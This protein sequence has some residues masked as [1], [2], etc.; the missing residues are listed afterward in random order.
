[1]CHALPAVRVSNRC[2]QAWPKRGASALRTDHLVSP[3][4]CQAARVSVQ[5]S[6]RAMAD[7]RSI[8]G[9][10]VRS[11]ATTQRGRRLGPACSRRSRSARAEREQPTSTTSCR[12]GKAEP[13]TSRTCRPSVTRAT[14]AKRI[15]MTVGSD[16]ELFEPRG[17]MARGQG[18]DRGSPDYPPRDRASPTEFTKN[19]TGLRARRGRAFTDRYSAL[20]GAVKI[21]GNPRGA[22]P[23]GVPARQGREIEMRCA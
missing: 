22:R 20:T 11:A 12:T 10:R 16:T 21:S 17:G 8:R 19:R 23:E 14:R 18:R 7:A 2:A 1:M 9:R 4:P 13:T 3:A 6:V 15:G 5:A